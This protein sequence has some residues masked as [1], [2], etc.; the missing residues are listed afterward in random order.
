[1]VFSSVDFSIF[2]STFWVVIISLQLRLFFHVWW[3]VVFVAIR[4][5]PPMLIPAGFYGPLTNMKQIVVSLVLADYEVWIAVVLWVSV[6]MVDYWLS[7]QFFSENINNL[8]PVF[9]L[10]IVQHFI[11]CFHTFL[12]Q[13][14]MI[15]EKIKTV[16]FRLLIADLGGFLGLLG[17][18]LLLIR[19]KSIP[20]QSRKS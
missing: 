18:V 10:P 5:H 6:N 17:Y 14:C 13:I 20:T 8:K 19:H 16:L 12:S 11:G 1:M 7:R 3:I 4:T 2:G 9:G 15:E